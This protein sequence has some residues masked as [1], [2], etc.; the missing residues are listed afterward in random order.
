MLSQANLR[1]HLASSRYIATSY[2]FSHYQV[3]ANGSVS[4]AAAARLVTGPRNKTKHLNAQHSLCLS[5]LTTP[6]FR[7]LSSSD[8]DSEDAGE[9]TL[10]VA[11][12]LNPLCHQHLTSRTV[13][14]RGAGIWLKSNVFLPIAVY[15]F[16]LL[17]SAHARRARRRNGTPRNSPMHEESNVACIWLLGCTI[18]TIRRR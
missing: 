6:R 18:Y 1:C 17:S 9:R 12:P 14:I 2:M 3:D 5:L 11:D 13:F 16:V 10:I 15:H 4:C 8:R 7:P